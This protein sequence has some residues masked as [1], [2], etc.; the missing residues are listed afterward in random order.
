MKLKGTWALVTGSSSGIGKCMAEQLAQRGIHLVL[1]ARRAD[2]LEAL[3]NE[4]RQ[5]YGVMAEYIAQDLAE[6][7]AAGILFEKTEGQ[8]KPIDILINNAGFGKHQ[9]FVESP[10]AIHQKQIQVNLTV[11]TE[12]THIY[13]V[14]MKAR[15]FGYIL[16][17]SSMAGFVPV[18]NYSVYAATKAYVTQFSEAIARELKDTP[19]RVCCLCPGATRTEFMEQAGQKLPPMDALLLMSAERCAKIGLKALFKGKAVVIS[20]WLN[21][22]AML[23]VR[24]LPRRFVTWAAGKV[25]SN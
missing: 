25:I 12:L 1:V 11:L 24:F 4:L 14:A 9:H 3:A 15:N 19:V 8:G 17:V 18:P 23:L 6:P 21:V 20:G 16:N 2:R 7:G 10:L 5:R 22:F 13:A